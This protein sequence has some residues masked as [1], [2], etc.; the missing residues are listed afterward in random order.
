MLCLM[1]SL[2]CAISVCCGCAAHAAP[3]H[4]RTRRGVTRGHGRIILCARARVMGQ[5]REC[6]GVFF[7]FF[8]F[9]VRWWCMMRE[10]ESG[11]VG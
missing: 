8:Y 7:G 11:R 5:V 10:R 3:P 1:L 9:R 2:L 4:A 6:A